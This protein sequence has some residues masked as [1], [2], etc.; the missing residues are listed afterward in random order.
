MKKFT[1]SVEQK[2]TK[3]VSS[4]SANNTNIST[5]EGVYGGCGALLSSPSCCYSDGVL[6]PGLEVRQSGG[7]DIFRNCQLERED[8]AKHKI[9]IIKAHS[10]V[11]PLV[12]SIHIRVSLCAA[13]YLSSVQFHYLGSDARGG[14]V[15]DPVM[16]DWTLNDAPHQSD[17]VVRRSRDSQIQGH[18]QA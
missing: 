6:S 18:V 8:A 11:G 9:F 3:E 15:G 17:G 13:M 10:L 1:S 5:C 16:V 14:R 12:C 2:K 4:A 7:G